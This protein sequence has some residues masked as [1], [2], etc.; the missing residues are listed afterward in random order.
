MSRR[1]WAFARRVFPALPPIIHTC[2]SCYA[3]HEYSRVCPH[4][5]VEPATSLNNGYLIDHHHFTMG[6]DLTDWALPLKIGVGR[7]NLHVQVLCIDFD[8]Y[9]GRW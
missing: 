5:G 9:W 7:A 3:V 1:L 2:T 8:L 4:C 6:Y